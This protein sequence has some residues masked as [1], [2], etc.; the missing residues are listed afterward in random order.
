MKMLTLDD[1]NFSNKKFQPGFIATSFPTAFDEEADSSLG[2]IIEEN[3]LADCSWWDDFTGY[4]EGIL[5][6]TD[7]YLENPQTFVYDLTPSKS[8]KIEFHPGDT[9]YFIN[10]QK[11]ACTGPHY[12]IQIFPLADLLEYVKFETRQ[13]IFLLLLPLVSIKEE[14]AARAVEIVQNILREFLPPS[15]REQIA[16]CIIYGLIEE[17]ARVDGSYKRSCCEAWPLFHTLLHLR[18]P[19]LFVQLRMD[20]RSPARKVQKDCEADRKSASRAFLK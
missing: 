18:S 4:Y 12:E 14:D 20:W 9:V 1:L 10:D 2:E 11:I 19:V 17:Q 7:G 8:L 5:E 15:F 16:N 13:E 3:H 6:E